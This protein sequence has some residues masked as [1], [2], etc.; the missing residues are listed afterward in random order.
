MNSARNF[1][2]LLKL[3][4]PLPPETTIPAFHVECLSGIYVGSTTDRF[5]NEVGGEFSPC[6]RQVLHQGHCPRC[7]GQSWVPEGPPQSN[8][9]D[10][11]ARRRE[12]EQRE[13][14]RYAMSV[15]QIVGRFD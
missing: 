9:I 10:L 8:P 1:L 15:L 5:G 2:V 12:M 7:G 3:V 13:A 4:D 6:G 14:D 11:A